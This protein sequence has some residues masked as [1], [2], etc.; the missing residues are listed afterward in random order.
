[1]IKRS[2][3]S[4]LAFWY[5]FPGEV[6]PTTDRAGELVAPRL[7]LLLLGSTSESGE[8]LRALFRP[9]KGRWR[10]LPELLI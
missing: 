1:M 10:A 7:G 3:R 2:I 5:Q 9:K 8:G 6:P 4:S